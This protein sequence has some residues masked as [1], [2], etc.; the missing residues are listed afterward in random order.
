MRKAEAAHVLSVPCDSH[1][2]QLIF[3]D[4]LFPGKDGHCNQITSGL[5]KFFKEF[6]N[7]IVSFFTSSDK[8][9]AYLREAME[10]CGGIVALITTVP[11]R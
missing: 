4:L 1:G 9:L 11:T 3:K 5:G 7:K 8:Q 10:K 2:I 6:P